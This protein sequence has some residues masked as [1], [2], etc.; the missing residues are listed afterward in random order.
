M[1]AANNLKQFLRNHTYDK[2]GNDIITH[3]RIGNEEKQI[4]GGSFEYDSAYQDS[5]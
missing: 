2:K 4:Y 1:H 3:T 5:L